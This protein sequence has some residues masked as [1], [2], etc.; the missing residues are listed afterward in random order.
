L[1]QVLQINDLCRE[2]RQIS[3][4]QNFLFSPIYLVG[5]CSLPQ[6]APLFTLFPHLIITPFSI[7]PEKILPCL[8]HSN[9]FTHFFKCGLLIALM[10]AAVHTSETLG[11]FNKTTQNYIPE[12]CHL[13]IHCCKNL[14]TQ[15][16]CFTNR[17]HDSDMPC[18]NVNTYVPWT[19]LYMPVFNYIDVAFNC[20]QISV[21]YC[22]QWN[23]VYSAHQRIIISIL[24]D[25]WLYS[26]S[27][28]NAFLLVWIVL[29]YITKT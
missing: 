8:T 24:C 1:V 13:Y 10:M 20:T 23:F 11:Y 12:S 15:R 27:Y 4:L 2:S 29:P 9:I 5:A 21:H 17:W 18:I 14:K 3:S 7:H 6:R 25:M 19:F 22:I 26:M 28:R 16:L